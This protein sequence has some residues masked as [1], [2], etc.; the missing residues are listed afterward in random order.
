MLFFEVTAPRNEKPGR[1]SSSGKLEESIFSY[2][3]LAPDVSHQK[4]KKRDPNFIVK[5]QQ[6]PI[7]LSLRQ[8]G[9]PKKIV[10]RWQREREK[11]QSTHVTEKTIPASEKDHR[12]NTEVISPTAQTWQLPAHNNNEREGEK[13]EMHPE[14]D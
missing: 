7:N 12:K 13:R 14:T 1:Q 5:K 9:R 10:N 4:R 3:I 6:T 2:E 8:G 11:I